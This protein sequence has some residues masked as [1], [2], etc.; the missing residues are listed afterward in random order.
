MPIF[1]SSIESNSILLNNL[2]KHKVF[3]SLYLQRFIE[4]FRFVCQTILAVRRHFLH[5]KF[6][7]KER[8]IRY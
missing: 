7:L 8:L 1:G 3:I 4:I 2:Q 6:K 5:T